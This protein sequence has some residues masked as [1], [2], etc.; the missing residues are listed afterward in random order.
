MVYF[1]KE[2]GVLARPWTVGTIDTAIRGRDEHVREV[3]IRYQNPTENAHRITRR[4]VRSV[5]R[6]FNV[7]E[8]SWRERWTTF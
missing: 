7:D 3:D 6:L 1:R 2:T 8:H 5:I 4:S